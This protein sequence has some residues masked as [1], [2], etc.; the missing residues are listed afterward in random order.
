MQNNYEAGLRLVHLLNKNVFSKGFQGQVIVS[1]LEARY[2][3]FLKG[4][5]DAA[6]NS[7]FGDQYF[8]TLGGV[9]KTMNLFGRPSSNSVLRTCIMRPE[10][11]PAFRN[12]SRTT[13]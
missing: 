1:G 2:I 11:P 4:A 6:T 10:S 8:Y 3:E 9:G 13:F 7:T 5:Q 12:P